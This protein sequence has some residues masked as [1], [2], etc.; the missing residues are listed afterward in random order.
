MVTWLLYNMEARIQ[1]QTEREGERERE[2]VRQE[3]VSPSFRS[4]V[5][6]LQPYIRRFTSLAHIQGKGILPH[7]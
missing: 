5:A 4:Q 6:S 1:G 2:R 7:L 3:M